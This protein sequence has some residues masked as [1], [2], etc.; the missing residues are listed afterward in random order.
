[1]IASRR[2][3]AVAKRLS[4]AIGWLVLTQFTLGVADIALKTPIWLQLLHLF[5]ADLLWIA[6][7][8]LASELM[9]PGLM[10]TE[11]ITIRN[12]A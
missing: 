7:V 11:N 5:T 2:V 9:P 8:L 1:M 10:R 12:A 4:V 3:N 6:C